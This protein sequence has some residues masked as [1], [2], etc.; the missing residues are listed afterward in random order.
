MTKSS[1]AEESDS[2]D[3]NKS[4]LH[5][6][7][8]TIKAI[9]KPKTIVPEVQTFDDTIA[10]LT[11]SANKMADDEKK[12]LNNFLEFGSK[13]VENIMIP[14]SDISAMQIDAKLEELK[15]ALV[16]HSHTRTLIYEDT[17]DNIIGFIHSKDLLKI[18]VKKQE[19]NLSK[20]IR[21]QIIS[22]P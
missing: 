11:F 18:W 10:K 20:L 13:T 12:I 7:K 3:E 8:S 1:N 4:Y 15:Q 21:K 17:L 14:R 16:D 9:F 6:L 5:K 19:F 2:K 22:A